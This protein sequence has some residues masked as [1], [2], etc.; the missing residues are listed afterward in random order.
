MRFWQT[1]QRRGRTLS[2]TERSAK[3]PV[4]GSEADQHHE[5][6]TISD[7]LKRWI[8]SHPELILE[9]RDL[10]RAL[11]SASDRAVGD[12]VVD[13]RGRAM[14][15]LES[16][17]GHLEE[18]HSTVIATAYENLTGMNQIHRAA[19]KLLE[20]VTLNGFLTCTRDELPKVL[21]VEAT[22]LLV[23][24]DRHAAVPLPRN[25]SNLL[26]Q[27]EPG[28]I[29]EYLTQGRDIPMRQIT[30]RQI[31]KGSVTVFDATTRE[32]RSEA[33]LALDLGR[34]KPPGMLVIGSKRA[35]EFE[36]AQGTDLMMF[37][38]GVFERSLRRLLP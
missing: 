23:E 29:E 4:D 24:K 1:G 6:V 8:L 30:L 17:L 18:T 13:L 10:M 38:A 12:N 7:D 32:V 5:D 9:D 37:F 11:V 19:L 31:Q 36:P 27:V 2:E 3:T 25:P 35:K 26:T 21:R 20:P 28:F 34:G 22:R 33:C 16:Q 15:R 14:E